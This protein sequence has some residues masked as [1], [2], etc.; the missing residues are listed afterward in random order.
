MEKKIM[1]M[2][3]PNFLLGSLLRFLKSILSTVTK[4]RI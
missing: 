3:F 1:K 2:Y 4:H